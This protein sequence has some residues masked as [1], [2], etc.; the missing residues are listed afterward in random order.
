V[1]GGGGARGC[2]G[3]GRGCERERQGCEREGEG[4]GGCEVV[5]AK[6]CNLFV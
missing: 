5:V 3:E 4:A 2:E 6:L 1:R